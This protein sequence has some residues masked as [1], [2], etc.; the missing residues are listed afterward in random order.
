MK[1]NDVNEINN[2]K[3]FDCYVDP[4]PFPIGYLATLL[5]N[6]CGVFNA[7]R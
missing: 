3:S 1:I 6:S 2:L 5:Q 7:S 4:N